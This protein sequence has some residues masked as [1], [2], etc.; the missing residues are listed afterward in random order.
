MIGKEQIMQNKFIHIC[1]GISF[2]MNILLGVCIINYEPV[3]EREHLDVV[4]WLDSYDYVSDEKMAKK[5]AG[6][7]FDLEDDWEI[8]ENSNYNM[9]VIYNDVR[10]EWIVIFSTKGILE[11]EKR[12]IGIGREHG[13]IIDYTG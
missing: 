1:L 7:Y 13:T 3:C 4:N 11:D 12:I 9:E 5:I 8:Q 6:A 10:Y 2:F